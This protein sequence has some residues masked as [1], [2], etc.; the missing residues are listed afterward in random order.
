MAVAITSRDLSAN[1]L[2]REANRSYG[3]MAAHYGVGVLPTRPRRPRDKAKGDKQRIVPL[4][5]PL[6]DDL[7]RLR[8]AHRNPRWLFPAR[9][10]AKPVSMHM[11][12]TTFRGAARSA[13]ITSCVT[14][15]A[16]RHSY[17]TRLLEQG[18]DTRVVQILLGHASISTTRAC[19]IVGGWSGG[20]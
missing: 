20:L 5:Q 17:A 7:R 8:R 18:V 1:E 3:A 16:L 15:H 4:P 6:L 14:P 12:G 9:D 11:L 2:R 13:G 10:D 19:K